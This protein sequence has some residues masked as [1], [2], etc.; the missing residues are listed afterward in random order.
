MVFT[1]GSG[2][3]SGVG[4]QDGSWLTNDQIWEMI[5]VEVGIGIWGSILELFGFI[6]ISMIELVDDRNPTLSKAT[7]AAATATVASIGVWGER[8]FQYRDSDNKKP[9]KFNGIKDPI[10]EMTR[11][12]S[13][14]W[15]FFGWGEGLVEIGE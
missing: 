15:T 13:A 9:P 5:V 2:Y 11:W 4:G 10:V 6:K 7:D 3:G 12:S 8:A 1:R 14:P